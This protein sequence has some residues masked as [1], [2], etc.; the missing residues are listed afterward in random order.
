MPVLGM[1]QEHHQA[2]LWRTRVSCAFQ[3][4]RTTRDRKTAETFFRVD[5]RASEAFVKQ[6]GNTVEGSKRDDLQIYSRSVTS[7][8]ALALIVGLGLVT[9]IWP[10]VVNLLSSSLDPQDPS[11]AAYLFVA[12]LSA[13]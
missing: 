11:T 7:K 9:Q 5:E 8:E 10:R 6:F 2:E 12:L 3:P 4:H 1:S 13:V